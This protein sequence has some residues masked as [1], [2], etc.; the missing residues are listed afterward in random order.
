MKYKSGIAVLVSSL[1]CGLL[2]GL[3]EGAAY[4]RFPL[5]RNP[6]LPWIAVLFDLLILLSLGCGLAL[7]ARFVSDRVL[8]TAANSIF[9]LILFYDF[10]TVGVGSHQQ[11][12]V[13][14]IVALVLAAVLGL[15]VYKFPAGWKSLQWRSLPWLAL[16]ALLSTGLPPLRR[17]LEERH[18]LA[19]V[20]SAA[21]A[22]NVLVI[23]A[24]TLRA[25]HLSA[26]GYGRNT[27]P[28]LAQFAAQ[29]ALFSNA[30]S[31][32][33]WTLPS[34]ASLL[35]GRLPHEHAADRPDSYL[36]GRFPT[37]AEAFRARGY[38]TAAF[39]ANWWYFARRL[40]FGRGF[41]HFEDFTSLISALAQTNM[42]QRLQ[43]M[44][45]KLKLLRAAVGRSRGDKVNRQ[46][47]RWLDRS[48]G[49]FFIVANY[50]D[51]HGPYLP[52]MHC[53]HRFS[54]RAR[55]P[56]LVFLGN[57]HL[58]ELT[59]AAVQDEVDA[60]DASIFCLD[61]EIASLQR[62]LQERGLLHDTIVVFTA[63]HGD[64][65]NEHG[66]M[67]HGNSLYWELIHVPLIMAGPGIPAGIKVDRPV[68]LMWLPAT[69]LTLSGGAPGPFPG[70]AMEEAWTKGEASQRRWPAPISELTAM[71]E[72]PRAPNFNSDLQSLVTP[73]WH[74]IVSSKRAAELYK[75]GT[76]SRERV[77]RA[78]A[79]E[80]VA[81]IL[82]RQLQREEVAASGPATSPPPAQ[83]KREQLQD[84][85]K[86]NDYLKALGYAP[87]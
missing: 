60:Y 35:T 61:S 46:I 11:R 48:Q 70:V 25:D 56:G 44:L 7:L 67:S 29:G 59:P 58:H 71:Y 17:A 6:D 52:P 45:L 12:L 57:P 77:N 82:S 27:S 75:Y 32:A 36:D 85:Q 79:D 66:L 51:V 78:A 20:S 74:L 13:L 16:F 83:R 54:R 53:F 69:L 42:G 84:R 10:T 55:P 23:I 40:G 47:L 76:D 24:D 1:W 50:M 19:Q 80:A 2:T 34:H 37:L 22:P 81:E 49:P 38:R 5:L 9:F 86:M 15:S 41:M 39:S 3:L 68:S 64:G 62:G 65:F 18:Q 8:L 4:W 14:R 73:A 87:Q 30:V 63:D 33:S 28:G 31:A 26:Y 72:D 43:N 21:H